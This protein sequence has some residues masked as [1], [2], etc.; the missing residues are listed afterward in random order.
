MNAILEEIFDQ[1]FGQTHINESEACFVENGLSEKTNN[2]F[3]SLAQLDDQ[4]LL[5]K[6]KAELL[7]A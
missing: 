7:P 6:L 3:A 1:T 4:T 5:E 2:F